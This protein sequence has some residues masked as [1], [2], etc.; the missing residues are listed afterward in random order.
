[1]THHR[2][3]FGKG[4]RHEPGPGVMSVEGAASEIVLMADP[5]VEAVP[6]RDIGGQFTPS[7]MR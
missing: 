5:L 6:A 1:V 4:S 2:P 7:D 3:T